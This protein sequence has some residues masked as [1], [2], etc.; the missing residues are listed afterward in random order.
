MD[1]EESVMRLL[2]KPL[3]WV[4]AVSV[5]VLAT[6]L[7]GYRPPRD[8]VTSRLYIAVVR[9]YQKLGRPALTGFVQCRYRPG[10]SD[11]SI[12]AVREY[13]IF[14]GLALTASRLHRCRTNVAP[15]TYDPIIRPDVVGD[16]RAVRE[17]N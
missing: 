5:L 7:D 17:P 6:A 16:K 2:A 15:D 14:R 9:G 3:F 11:Y 12:E 4:V 8:Q 1:G 13:G 10:C